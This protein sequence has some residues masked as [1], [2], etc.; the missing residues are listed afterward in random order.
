MTCDEIPNPNVDSFIQP[1]VDIDVSYVECAVSVRYR[2]IL[3]GVM[4]WC[5]ALCKFDS[6]DA[7]PVIKTLGRIPNYFI[8]IK[9]WLTTTDGIHKYERNISGVK[10]GKIYIFITEGIRHPTVLVNDEPCDKYKYSN[11]SDCPCILF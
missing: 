7:V 3:D 1:V 2:A 5:D 4:E 8:S 9:V 11:E 6:G 10:S